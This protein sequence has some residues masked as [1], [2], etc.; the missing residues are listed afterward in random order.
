M[1]I[2]IIESGWAGFTGDLGPIAFVDGIS[3]DD[4]GSADAS[5]LAGI[6]SVENADTGKNPSISQ[7]IVD[8]YDQTAK[9][10]AAI[11]AAATVIPGDFTKEQ[12]EAI[13]DS[14]G[15]KGVR[16]VSDPLGVKGNSITELIDKVLSAQTARATATAPAVDPAAGA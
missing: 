7:R 9:V 10:E 6:L 2:R 15:I 4:V 8:S 3:V 5:Y 14:G 16:E 12:L 1:K 11:I 13:A